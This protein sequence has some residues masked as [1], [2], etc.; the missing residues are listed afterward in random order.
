LKRWFEVVA[1]RPAVQRAYARA[2]EVND[3]PVVSEA[4]KDILF[5]QT[6]AAIAGRR[7]QRLA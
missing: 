4:A 3:Q 6:A 1:A 7:T 2:R 5:G